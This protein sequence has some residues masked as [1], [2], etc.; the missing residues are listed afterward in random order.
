MAWYNPWAEARE[1]KSIVAEY[2]AQVG[3]LDRQIK[4]LE[5]SKRENEREIDVLETELKAAKAALAEAVKNDTRDSKG[6]FT[7]AK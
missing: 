1:L 5:F 6:R 4:K 2:R 7:K 3:I